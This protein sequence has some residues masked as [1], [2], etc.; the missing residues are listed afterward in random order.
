MNKI[1]DIV[2]SMKESGIEPTFETDFNILRSHA[3]HG[4]IAAILSELPSLKLNGFHLQT[5]HV[6]QLIYDLAVNGH[7]AVC[8]RLFGLLQKGS[9]YSRLVANTVSRLIHLNQDD[10]AYSLIKTLPKQLM[11]SHENIVEYFLDRIMKK[12][13]PFKDVATICFRIQE[14]ELHSN[15]LEIIYPKIIDPKLCNELWTIIRERKSKG[16][17]AVEDHFRSFF[18][19]SNE[20]DVCETLRIMARDFDIKPTVDFLTEVVIPKLDH[21]SPIDIVNTLLSASVTPTHTALAVIH[22]CLQYNQFREAV[23]L[24]KQFNLSLRM[25][26][27]EPLLISVFKTTR[28]IDSYVQFLRAQY[29]YYEPMNDAVKV[30]TN[31][32]SRADA[33]GSILF[34]TLI[35]ISP[36]DR[37]EILTNVLKGMIDQGIGISYMQAKQI[38]NVQ[39]STK[40]ISKYL[41]QLTS[42][43]LNLK[44]IQKPNLKIHSTSKRLENR[45]AVKLP[46]NKFELLSSYRR[47][48]EN[49]KF[50]ELLEQLESEK[51]DISPKVYEHLIQIKLKE[52]NLDKVFDI[53]DKCKA[54]KSDFYLYQETII[55]IVSLFIDYGRVDEAVQFLEKT[56][57]NNNMHFGASE[58]QFKL[59]NRLAE[60]GRATEVC[61]IFNSL[62]ENRH[63][64][65]N[66]KLVSPLV[67]V[68]LVNENIAK[69]IDTFEQY[70]ANYKFTPYKNELYIRLISR[71]DWT[72]LERVQAVAEKIHGKGNS[73]IDLAF[74]LI[75]CNEIERAKQ[76]FEEPS[77]HISSQKIDNWYR[78]ITAQNSSD[79]A[80]AINCLRAL[81]KVTENCP[82]KINR[83]RTYINLLNLYVQEDKSI[84][85][86][87]LFLQIG[88]DNES[89]SSDFMAKLGKYLKSKNVDVP[90]VVPLQKWEGR[91]EKFEKPKSN[92]R[93]VPKP[94]FKPA[95]TMFIEQLEKG[96]FTKIREAYHQLPEQYLIASIGEISDRKTVAL[97]FLFEALAED[98][99]VLALEKINSLLSETKQNG[100][101]YENSRAKAYALCGR[102]QQWIVEW[103]EKAD[104]TK[105]LKILEKTFPVNGFYTLLERNPHLLAKC[106]CYY[107]QNSHS[108]LSH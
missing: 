26:L 84:E 86:K 103:I 11:T 18:V 38:E 29:E 104:E 44:P 83:E 4:D 16:L 50:E 85:I 99:D 69:A 105:D 79:S 58:P 60:E 78:S 25:N 46:V 36:K 28:D 108:V 12:N 23:D 30:S 2:A 57:R 53:Y 31:V 82:T 92:H 89:V 48:N 21:L 1:W 77:L 20:T 106:K 7:S 94:V 43:Q 100:I 97:F 68:H 98:G 88:E 33:I 6:L 80:S 37:V 15:P 59:L 17:S 64:P 72:N 93:S 73:L 35:E 56:K 62:I 39:P 51:T 41:E 71:K 34:S 95:K 5:H 22:H 90:F 96:N 19:S 102:A 101:W 24:M 91:Q 55:Q 14:D 27:Y 40:E 76:I 54:R 13:R 8:N 32:A 67:K 74:R 49:N 107:F 10:V 3:R 52:K 9:Y 63:I 61:K 42:E 87:D 47:E 70:A 45:A 75:E 81:L 65:I 66:G